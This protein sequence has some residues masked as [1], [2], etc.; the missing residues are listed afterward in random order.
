MPTFPLASPESYGVGTVAWE[1]RSNDSYA[2]NP[3]SL[4]LVKQIFDGRMWQGTLTIVPQKATQGRA[5]SAWLTALRRAGTNAGT[6][7]LGDPSASQPLGSAKDT[8]GTPVVSGAGQTGEAL[9]V[10]GLPLSA[11]GYL[12]AGDYIQIGTG[13][14]SRLKKVLDQV[15]SDA[16]GLATINVWPPI[17]TAPADASAIVVSNPQGVF[18]SPSGSSRWQVR[19]GIYGVTIDVAEVVP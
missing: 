16:G 10:S 2:R 8:P 15:D 13:A 1:A 12:L 5:L 7:L 3:W 17:R 9:N 14:S 4:D 11:T 19:N 6:F 18:V